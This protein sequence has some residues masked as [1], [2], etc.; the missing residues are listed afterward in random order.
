MVAT[1]P[2]PATLQPTMKQTKQAEPYA[3]L[4]NDIHVGKDNIPEFQKNWDE[5]LDVCDEYGISKIIVGG[6]LFKSRSSQSL[7]VL[8]AV[9]QAIQTAVKA[10]VKLI[11][12]NG[13][14]DLVDQE[15]TLGYCH[16]FSEYPGVEVVN[17]SYA[18]NLD[19]GITFVVMRYF[20]EDTAFGKEFDKVCQL[21]PQPDYRS[22]TILYLHEGISGAIAT[23]SE[24]E[25]PA[26]MFKGF[27]KVLVGHYHDR[28]K[29]KGTS[30]EYIG[31]SRQH[32]FGE[33]EEKGYTIMYMDGST[34][35]IKNTINTRYCTVEIDASE[36]TDAP[37]LVSQAI[38]NGHKVRVKINGSA[39]KVK[40][41]D[42]QKLIDLGV[43]KVEVVSDIELTETHSQDFDTKYDK[44][45]LKK[46]YSEFCRQKDIQEIETGLKYLDK[47]EA[48]CG[49]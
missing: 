19:N 3:L 26:S 27:M 39:D 33:D 43:A 34:K 1:M 12:A 21:L 35:F 47:I 2:C 36:M 16:I 23:A 48:P 40:Q 25:L 15:A 49:L 14:H 37:E 11:L 41:A 18:E 20:P 32:N 28:C 7:N 44:A 46:E 8:M 4:I 10:G 5:A 9:R 29:I 22:K 31:A 13:N 24:K 30:I 45:G 42:K 6:D 17:G 38:E